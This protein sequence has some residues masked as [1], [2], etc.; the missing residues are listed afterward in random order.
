M[1]SHPAWS[2]VVL[3]SLALAVD[4]E[5]EILCGQPALGKL[6]GSAEGEVKA[7][8]NGLDGELAP[9]NIVRVLRDVVLQKISQCFQQS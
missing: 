7:L 8:E 9:L 3:S 4:T 6:F 1:T 5:S 2:T